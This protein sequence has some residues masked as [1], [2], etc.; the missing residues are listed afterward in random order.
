MSQGLSETSV[1]LDFC[2]SDQSKSLRSQFARAW[3]ESLLQ[4]RQ[5][6]DRQQ[7]QRAHVAAYARRHPENDDAA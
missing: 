6:F 5:D 7:E 4:A 2:G 3:P 1:V